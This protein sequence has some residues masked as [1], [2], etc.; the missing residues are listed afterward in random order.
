MRTAHKFRIYPNKQ[1]SA[2]LDLT[3]ETCRRLWNIALEDR[4]VNWELNGINRSYEDQAAI[5]TSEKKIYPE[6]CS[7][8]SQVLQDVLKRLKKAFDNFFRRV[9]AHE[10]EKGYPRF[11]SKGRYNS[12]TYPQSGFKLDGSRLTLAKI[13]GTM[14]TFV[15]RP[16]VG[17]VK[18]C[19]LK[20]DGRGAWFVI[21]VTEQEDPVKIEP[22]IAIGVD[23]GISHAVTT[24]EGQTF[25]YP[26]C[27]VQAEKKN[28]AAEKSLHR[29]KLGSRNRGKARVKLSCIGKRV[30]NLR[31]EFCHQVSRKL[32]DS[33]D[34]IVFEDLQIQNML[35]NHHLAKHVS[36]VSWGKLIQFTAS[37]AARAGK[38]VE[39]VDPRN[40][41][42]RCSDCGEIVLKELS[43]RTHS[44]PNCGLQLDRDHNAAR[45]ILT[46]GL[47]GIACGELTSGLGIRLSKRQLCE[48]GSPTP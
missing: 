12:I 39:L 18:T 1:Q 45:N 33:A 6:L 48:A 22:T 3:L 24:S 26:R 31:D 36:D 42:Q 43:E 30:T 10:K 25:D 2:T 17:K 11:K 5:L 46:L 14:R 47:R 38:T 37:K 15:H 9:K 35:K 16:V 23:L 4:K 32:V 28:R 7:V 41:S 34:L 40:T 13:P 29:K 20:R 8:Y 21:F 27:Y 44:C 19:T